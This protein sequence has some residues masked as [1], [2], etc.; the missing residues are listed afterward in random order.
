MKQPCRY[1]IVD[2]DKTSNLI[3]DFIIQRFDKEAQRSLFT[4]PEEALDFIS[5][6]GNIDCVTVLLL[7]INMP[8]MTG[9]EFLREFDKLKREIK[10]QCKV[11]MLTSSIE[12]FSSKAE[13]FPM[14][15]KYFSKP[16]KPIYLDQICTELKHDYI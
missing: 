12:D 16:L 3:C 7:D 15:I 4:S 5:K 2:D 1:L 10:D 13:E 9:F 11:Y 8:T 6:K 14:V